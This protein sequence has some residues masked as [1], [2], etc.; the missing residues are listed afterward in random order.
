MNSEEFA[1]L[2]TLERAQRLHQDATAAHAQR[3]MRLDDGYAKL[4]EIAAD[5]AESN[6]RLEDTLL[7]LN[8]QHTARMGRLED[9][10]E[11]RRTQHTERMAELEQMHQDM[12]T[13]HT[14]RMDQHG[15]RMAHLESILDAIKELLQRRNGGS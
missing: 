13:Q 15:A 14:E 1:R 3:I 8:A 9:L 6:H 12:Q 10:L 5:V 4:I 7:R 11:T 2:S